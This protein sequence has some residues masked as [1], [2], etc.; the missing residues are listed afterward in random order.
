MVG[1]C[2]LAIILLVCIVL[3]WAFMGRGGTQGALTTTFVGYTNAPGSSLRF[4][5]F[6]ASNSASHSIRWRGCWV[7]IEGSPNHKAPIM[8]PSLPGFSYAPVLKTRERLQFAIGEPTSDEPGRWRFV[9]SFSRYTMAARWLDFSYQHKL[10]PWLN[11]IVM[12]DQQ[13]I[14]NPSNNIESATEWLA[15]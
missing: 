3:A 11:R 14:L 8:N 7:E 12:V 9:A 10:P 2:G 15:K 6:C 4:A 13:R 1:T 5:L